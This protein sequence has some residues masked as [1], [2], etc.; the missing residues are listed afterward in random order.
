MD[1]Q[2]GEGQTSGQANVMAVWNL[3]FGLDTGCCNPLQLFFFQKDCK[4]EEN[5]AV[6]VIYVLD[7]FKSDYESSHDIS[8]I[9]V[10]V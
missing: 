10:R 6:A 5:V 9:L 3:L 7:A 1:G 8:A 2:M 4:V